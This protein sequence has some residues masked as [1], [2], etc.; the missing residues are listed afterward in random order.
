MVRALQAARPTLSIMDEFA[1]SKVHRHASVILDA[2][3]RRV[4]RACEGSSR[5]SMRPIVED[6]PDLS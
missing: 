3:T 2:N 1:L 5:R 4:L 6:Q